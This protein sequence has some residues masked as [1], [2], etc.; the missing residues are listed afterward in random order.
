[1]PPNPRGGGS[2]RTRTSDSCPGRGR[3]WRC[4]PGTPLYPGHTWGR[5]P[6]PAHLRC[7][8]PKALTSRH[9]PSAPPHRSGAPKRRP[10]GPDPPHPNATL[11]PLPPRSLCPTTPLPEAPHQVSTSPFPQPLGCARLTAGPP[12][13]LSRH[14]PAIA[15]HPVLA[16]G[17]G[18][19]GAAHGAGAE[20]VHAGGERG[21]GR[22]GRA[23]PGEAAGRLRAAQQ[24]APPAAP[25]LQPRPQHPRRAAAPRAHPCALRQSARAAPPSAAAPR[26]SRRPPAADQWAERSPA[27]ISRQPARG[28]GKEAWPMP[29]RGGAGR[30]SGQRSGEG[31]GRCSGACLL[32]ANRVA[33]RALCKRGAR[34]PAPGAGVA[35]LRAGR[36]GGGRAAGSGLSRAAPRPWLG[37]LPARMALTGPGL[38]AQSRARGHGCD[39]PRLAAG[40]GVRPSSR[41]SPPQSRGSVHRG[42]GTR[43][44]RP[45]ASR[46]GAA[47]AGVNRSLPRQDSPAVPLGGRD[48]PFAP[49]AVGSA[50]SAHASGCVCLGSPGSLEVMSQ[51][52]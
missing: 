24:P 2:L 51:V 20:P 16:G 31:R 1:M 52:F 22:A 47:C 40:L 11:W 32:L 12:R 29:R 36:E 42:G 3:R 38:G 6:H 9:G 41:V 8:L 15:A 48:R 23:G 13:Y 25:I 44:C 19:G 35:G 5:L 43:C 34:S 30:V 37:A 27:P 33:Q 10:P 49:G 17:R 28:G 50:R 46:A 14:L 39:E 7:P 26:Q 45:K 4:R 18:G 21:A